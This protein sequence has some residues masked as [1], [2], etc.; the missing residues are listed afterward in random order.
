[1]AQKEMTPKEKRIWRV[2]FLIGILITLALI[3]LVR[4]LDAIKALVDEYCIDV[5]RLPV[6]ETPAKYGLEYQEIDVEVEPGIRLKTWYIPSQLAE[7]LVI[8]VPGYEGTRETL[9]P[10]IQFFH[11]VG[12]STLAID[13]RGQGESDGESICGSYLASD[14]GKIVQFFNQKG[15]SKFVLFG[16]SL[17]AVGSI[18]AGAQNEEVVGVIADS[19][20]ANLRQGLRHSPSCQASI[21]FDNS[22]LYKL[23]QAFVPIYIHNA[24]GEFIDPTKATDAL[25]HVK[26]VR[27]ILLIHGKNDTVI[28]VENAYLLFEKAQ[29]TPGIKELWIYEGDHAEG[30]MKHPTEYKR[31]VLGFIKRITE[32]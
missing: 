24:F 23:F 6:K 27:N 32:G 9:L 18:I 22:L 5:A 12:Y 16:V 7:P 20:F 29:K 8:L 31:K 17:G 13:P 4:T 30:F 1:M 14:L 3:G 15:V 21:L 26:D 11:E 10:G 25:S 28:P 19:A 2:I